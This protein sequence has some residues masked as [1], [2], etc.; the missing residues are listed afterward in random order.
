[1]STPKAENFDAESVRIEAAARLRLVADQLVRI[2]EELSSSG[3]NAKR[4]SVISEQA[5]L[6]ADDLRGVAGRL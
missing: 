2:G 3:M 4:A 1:M 5:W 6:L